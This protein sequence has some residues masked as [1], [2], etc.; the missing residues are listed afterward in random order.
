M[1]EEHDKTKGEGGKQYQ[2]EDKDEQESHG[3]K[4]GLIEKPRRKDVP[5]AIV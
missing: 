2:P 5:G 3:K 1:L 4:Q